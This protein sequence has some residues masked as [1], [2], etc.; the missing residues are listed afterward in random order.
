MIV[1]IATDNG[2]K[3]Y[4]GDDVTV[5]KDVT[6]DQITDGSLWS[7]AEMVISDKFDRNI[8]G[9]VSSSGLVGGP[10]PRLTVITMYVK[11]DYRTIVTDHAGYIMNEAGKTIDRIG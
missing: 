4:E 5:R 11:D 7:A 6:Y 9:S 1:K 3:Y 8:A 10:I 2:F